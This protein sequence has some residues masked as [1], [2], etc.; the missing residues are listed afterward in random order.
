MD[1]NP[2]A[3][4]YDLYNGAAGGVK[5]LCFSASGVLI[6][7]TALA[8]IDRIAKL[9]PSS[10][11]KQ[12]VTNRKFATCA[13]AIIGHL[14][15]TQQKV[16]VIGIAGESGAGKTTLASSMKQ[17][18]DD[19]G[20]SSILL[21]QDDYFKL[22]PRKNTEARL[23]NFEHVG[24]GEVD[25]ER[26]NSDLRTI[27]QQQFSKI[28][29]P[30][31]NWLTDDCETV[32]KDVKDVRV[33]ILEGTYTLLPKEVDFRIFINTNYKQTLENRHQR[34]RETIDDFT[35]KILHKESGL[36]Q[37]QEPLADLIVNS[38]LDITE[39]EK[40]SKP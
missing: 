27:A 30:K 25:T 32:E 22:P 7:N 4:Y 31:M 3:E 5:N 39:T 19:M 24:Y 8:D 9:L 28:A 15:L 11:E 38:R 21:H 40:K 16:L 35:D 33:I 12:L 26:L 36:V 1:K 6:A 34:S 14:N 10:V 17:C 29:I 2:F 18:F 37:A 13:S 20:I 23:L